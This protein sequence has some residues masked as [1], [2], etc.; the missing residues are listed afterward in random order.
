[1]SLF[2]HISIKNK[3]VSIILFVSTL[4]MV[5]GFTIV[6]ISNVKS[7]KKEMHLNTLMNTRLIGEYSVAPLTFDDNAGAENILSKLST[8]PGAVS[9]ALYDRNGFLF[10]SY[11]RS[12]DIFIQ[13][14]YKNPDELTESLSFFTKNILKVDHPIIYN[15]YE[16]GIIVIQVETT[17]LNKK[18]KDF[19]YIM[20]SILAGMFILAFFLANRF[21][22]PISQPILELAKLT[23]KISV[24]G[25]YD[26]KLERSS[27]DEIGILYEDFNNML[28]QILIR[29]AA[30]D[31]AEK[32]LQKEKERAEESDQLKSAFLANMSH[33][34]RTPMNAILGFTELIT[35]P[36]SE[37]TPEEKENFIKLINN[38]A[39]NLLQ[40]IDDI[41]DISKIEA[42]QLKIIKK[43]C[44]LNSTLKDIWQSFLEIR[45]HKGKEKVD[46]RLNESA[47]EQNI[48]IKTDPLRLNQVLTNLIDNALKFTED[49]FIEFGYEIQNGKQ[50]LFYVKDTGVGMDQKKKDFVFDRFIKLE[51][52]SSRLYRGAGLGLAICKSLVE[53][54]NG[55]IWVESA[56]NIGSTFYF[57]LPFDQVHA[58]EN[59]MKIVD[60]NEIYNWHDKT[61]LVAEDE[62]AN[63]IYIEEVLKIT[64]A[65]I[66]KAVNGKEA[67]DMI[68]NNSNIDII[69]MD[70]KMPVMDGYEATRRI[71]SLRKDIPI[72]SQSAYAMPGDIDK[73]L[74]SGMNDY[75]I[76]P[77]KPKVLLSILNKHLNQLSPTG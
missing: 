71:K 52:N 45:K 11:K 59:S 41:I 2:Q 30:R 34:I 42:E 21:Q 64:K 51:D 8:I 9:G 75:L 3:L 18:I 47:L 12:D 37:V 35:M 20:A 53:L 56:P 62:P 57:T 6:G 48:F 1:M 28:Q 10:A 7:L 61:I 33:E 36:D 5:I 74:E 38:S 17:L 68:S 32:K 25:N 65:K 66:L 77:V 14:L 39:N 60:V 50:L 43:D 23:R 70:I 13:P 49:G 15:N 19:I 31:E 72:I 44:A 76:K 55:K 4:T 24:E 16:Y 40:L 26:V 29:E 73:G 27:N 69:I 63:Y 46:I 58:S 22:K 54:L 67:V